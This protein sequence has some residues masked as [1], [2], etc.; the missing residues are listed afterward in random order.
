MIDISA[1]NNRLVKQDEALSLRLNHGCWSGCS[2]DGWVAG[3]WG[4][5]GAF[6]SSGSCS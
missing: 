3:S 2:F 6:G 5:S 4:F 1:T